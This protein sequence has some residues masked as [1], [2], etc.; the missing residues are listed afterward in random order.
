VYLDQ[1]FGDDSRSRCRP[2]GCH[3]KSSERGCSS[4][5]HR[6]R[7]HSMPECDCSSAMWVYVGPF[8]FGIILSCALNHESPGNFVEREPSLA[9]DIL[10]PGRRAVYPTTLTPF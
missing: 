8:P 9:S 6:S 5:G 4:H 2:I 1:P 3:R 10:C 7:G